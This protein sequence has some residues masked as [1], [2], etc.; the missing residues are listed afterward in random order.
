MHKQIETKYVKYNFNSKR[1]S[2]KVKR[3]QLNNVTEVSGK[4]GFYGKPF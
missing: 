2:N 3:L 1:G 4:E